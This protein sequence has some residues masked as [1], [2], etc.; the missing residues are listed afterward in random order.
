MCTP[1]AEAKQTTF[2]HLHGVVNNELQ[3]A[4]NLDLETATAADLT[5][6]SVHGHCQVQMARW[7]DEPKT[8]Y[9]FLCLN[10]LPVAACTS[11]GQSEIRSPV[12]KAYTHQRR[13]DPVHL[14][15]YQ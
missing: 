11:T 13:K 4:E 8:L 5:L 9:N 12:I 15:W 3:P 7:Q 6:Q 14:N 10:Y 2:A 1:A